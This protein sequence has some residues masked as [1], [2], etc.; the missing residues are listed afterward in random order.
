VVPP[1]FT[2]RRPAA[3][4]PRFLGEKDGPTRWGG[5]AI[6]NFSKTLPGLRGSHVLSG[7]GHWVQQERPRE[8]NELLVKFVKGL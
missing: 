6:A 4:W 5:A 2:H 3:L 8:V 1:S 7:C